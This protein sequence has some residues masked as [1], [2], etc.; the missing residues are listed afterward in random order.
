MTNV[1]H[2]ADFHST[3]L[4]STPE[5]A[6]ALHSIASSPG[7]GEPDA[8]EARRWVTPAI[9]AA[10]P[11]ALQEAE[12]LLQPA[13]IADAKRYIGPIL[14][15]VAPSSMTA[16]DQAGWFAAALAGLSGIPAD[17]LRDACESRAMKLVQFPSQIVAT[18][19]TEVG[20][21]WDRRKRMLENAKRLARATDLPGAA[22]PLVP[23]CSPEEARDILTQH[24][25][26]G[27]ATKLK[28]SG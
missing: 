16:D 1:A 26:G 4:V 10:L 24:G 28:K 3:R 22:Q 12:A 17:L 11:A 7:W 2:I 8:R 27:I 9:K 5:G 18:T 21:L 14:A 23:N 13:T 6:R 20:P 15:I 25:F 19:F